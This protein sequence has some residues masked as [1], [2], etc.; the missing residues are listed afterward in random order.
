MFR[1][2]TRERP[3]RDHAPCSARHVAVFRQ[4]Y[5]SV[6]NALSSTIVPWANDRVSG[7]ARCESRA[8]TSGSNTEDAGGSCYAVASSS[9]DLLRPTGRQERGQIL[10]RGG[11]EADWTLP[12]I[13]GGLAKTSSAGARALTMTRTRS[14]PITPDMSGVRGGT[15]TLRTWA[16]RVE[17]ALP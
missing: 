3:D 9:S 2:A 17:L 1:R 10:T 14:G 4:H 15:Q 16:L 5:G 8:S 12:K 6:L 11:H 13:A 7:S